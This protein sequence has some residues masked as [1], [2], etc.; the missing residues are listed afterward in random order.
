MKMMLGLKKGGKRGE[1]KQAIR[2]LI[3][4]QNVGLASLLETKEALWDDLVNMH[5]RIK[6]PWLLLGDINCVLNTEECI[7]SNV[8]ISEML[9]GRKCFKACGLIDI[10]FGGNFFTWSN[11]Q[12]GE[13][14]VFSKIDRV[15]ANKEWLDTYDKANA[16]FLT[17]GVSDRCPAPV[18]MKNGRKHGRS[19]SS[20]IRCGVKLLIIRRG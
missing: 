18:R 10:P 8:R 4:Q 2:Q 15:M 11:K 14:R 13:D 9:P 17:E 3:A 5:S 16:L 12:A 20:I 7:G 6:G 1:K 19:I